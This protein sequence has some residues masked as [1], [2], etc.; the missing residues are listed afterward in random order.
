MSQSDSAVSFLFPHK[1]S[2]AEH[3]HLLQR[4]R[5]GININYLQL[6]KSAAGDVYHLTEK[7]AL[8]A[9]S[10]NETLLPELFPQLNEFGFLP[11]WTS[12]FRAQSA[13]G[14][15]TPSVR[16]ERKTDDVMW[17]PSNSSWVFT[18]RFK[19]NWP[20]TVSVWSEDKVK[21]AAVIFSC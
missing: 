11:S 1:R 14:L 20:L 18:G 7:V 2:L 21:T 9:P 4:A 15:R 16:S 19:S 10:E 17:Q 12:S 8:S 13:D 3:T 6:I 5:Y